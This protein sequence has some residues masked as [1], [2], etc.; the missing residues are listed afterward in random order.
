MH[1][2][3]SKIILILGLLTCG[4]ETQQIDS[5][6]VKYECTQ[7]IVDGKYQVKFDSLE[8]KCGSLEDTLLNVIYG[9]PSP[10]PN[11]G[12]HLVK[13][14][15]KEKSCEVR[16]IFECDD[17]LWKMRM[18]WNTKSDPASIDMI[19]GTLFVNMERFTGW[20]CQGLYEYEGTKQNENR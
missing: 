16:A 15:N 8:T 7:P 5:A 11:A 9:V 18:D 1:I 20:N 10:N 17:G 12:C 14:S 4:G 3:K 2:M 6:T 19:K 13:V